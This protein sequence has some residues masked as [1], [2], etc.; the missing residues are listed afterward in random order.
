[1]GFPFLDDGVMVLKIG[2]NQHY[3]PQHQ[4]LHTVIMAQSPSTNLSNF[5]AKNIL[6]RSKFP[7][8]ERHT[9]VAHLHE[10]KNSSYQILEDKQKQ[11]NLKL[12]S[13]DD[14]KRFDMFIYM[15]I[16]SILQ[17]LVIATLSKPQ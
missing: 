14:F 16:M 5:Y 9:S 6:R 11:L 1:M 7:K 17:C 12:H 2:S 15:L 3:S 10:K 8:W 13:G 4:L